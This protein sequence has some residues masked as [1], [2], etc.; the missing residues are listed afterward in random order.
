MLRHLLTLLAK[1][2]KLCTSKALQG[3]NDA[4]TTW[5]EYN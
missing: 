2:D 5:H 3:Y 4:S 1:L